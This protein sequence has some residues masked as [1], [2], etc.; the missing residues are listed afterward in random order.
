M[1][2]NLKDPYC[3]GSSF[4]SSTSREGR[5]KERDLGVKRSSPSFASTIWLSSI[6][7]VPP[8]A[9]PSSTCSSTLDLFVLCLLQLHSGCLFH[10]I[11]FSFALLPI[12]CPPP[13]AAFPFCNFY[14]LVQSC[15]LPILAA[16]PT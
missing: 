11:L 15:W 14:E 9:S 16:F 2:E 7:S 13:A 8:P 6:C 1:R 3:P 5:W 10:Y 4:S 12:P